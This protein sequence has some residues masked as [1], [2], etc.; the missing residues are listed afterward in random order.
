MRLPRVRFSVA[1]M[2]LAVAL[3]GAVCGEEVTRRRR[4]R[5]LLALAT[6]RTWQE[7]AY[8]GQARRNILN[9]ELYEDPPA[10]EVALQKKWK[11][12]HPLPHRGAWRITRVGR[13]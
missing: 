12:M 2:M 10:T 11:E 5:A 6:E 3:L 9:A 7:Y 8:K 4:G 1:R 13:T